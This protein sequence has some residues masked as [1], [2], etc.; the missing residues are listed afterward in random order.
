MLIENIASAQIVLEIPLERLNKTQ[1]LECYRR[2]PSGS[3]LGLFEYLNTL[4]NDT[5]FSTLHKSS[6]ATEAVGSALLGAAGKKNL[7]F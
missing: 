3:R 2:I 1:P 5:G 7:L 6:R 4:H